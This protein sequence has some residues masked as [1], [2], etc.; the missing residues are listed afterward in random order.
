MTSQLYGCSLN[1]AE[2]ARTTERYNQA[3]GGVSASAHFDGNVARV[4]LRGD[5]PRIA[6]LLDDM[7]AR[8]ADCCAHLQ[9][10]V[11]ETEEGYGVA[12]STNGIP[13]L[14]RPVLADALSVLFPTAMVS[15]LDDDDAGRTAIPTI[16]RDEIKA[17]L[18]RGEPL[19]FIEA[20]PEMYFRKAHLPGALNISVEQLAERAAALLP[21]KHAPIVVYCANLACKNSSLATAWLIEHGYTNVHDYAD[22]KQDWIDA[23]LPTERGRVATG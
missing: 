23:G 17:R 19:V 5:K 22:G 7:I 9:F 21:D 14:E 15:E 12:L 6:A 8:E 1:E 16:A 4:D 2:F 10:E 13:G 18:G 11:E 20:L 3:A